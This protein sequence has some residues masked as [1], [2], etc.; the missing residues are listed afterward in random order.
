MTEVP[1][2]DG[3]LEVVTFRRRGV[4]E[5][6]EA[7][8]VPSYGKA[9]VR[10]ASEGVE[11]L[12]EEEP[13]RPVFEG[14][15]RARRKAAAEARK[16]VAAG[17]PA[18][19][20]QSQAALEEDVRTAFAHACERSERARDERLAEM[21]SRHHRNR[22][23][24]WEWM[25]VQALEGRIIDTLT[26][27]ERAARMVAFDEECRR[28]EALKRAAEAASGRLT[29]AYGNRFFA[30]GDLVTRDGTDVHRV[31]DHNGSEGH[32]PD[33]MTVVCVKAPASGW[34]EVGEEEFNVCRRYEWIEPVEC[35]AS[36]RDADLSAVG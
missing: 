30:V 5:I 32:A 8:R 2:M 9:D 35:P 6:A 29:D 21:L 3:M 11:V 27:E 16:G 7:M 10:F 28:I 23:Y 12:L 1:E 14:N 33:G 15:R 25:R 26:P 13:E 36:G 24:T 17:Q 22:Q 34:T 31:V 20:D 18:R 19:I 4:A